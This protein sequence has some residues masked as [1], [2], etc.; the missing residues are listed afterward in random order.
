MDY[1]TAFAFNQSLRHVHKCRLLHWPMR[2]EERGVDKFECPSASVLYHYP[3]LKIDRSH[4][5]KEFRCH[6]FTVLAGALSPLAG[7]TLSFQGLPHTTRYGQE[8][9]DQWFLTFF[10]K[11]AENKGTL[12]LRFIIPSYAPG[13]LTHTSVWQVF[14]LLRPMCWI[15]GFNNYTISLSECN[16]TEPKW[17]T[18]GKH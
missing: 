2:C 3:S 16:K 11:H 4:L 10:L 18:L 17:Q 8:T 6:A 14:P 7:S 15:L 1:W 9:N 12:L 5:K 13:Y